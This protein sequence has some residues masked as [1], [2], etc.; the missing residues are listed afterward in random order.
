M[1]KNIKSCVNVNNCQSDFFSSNAGVR[2]GENLSPLLFSLFIND[3]E[4]HMTDMGN[5]YLD[6]SDET[7]N[8]F[9]KL[10]LLLYADDTVVFSNSPTGLQKCLDDLYIYCNK[11]KLTVN[12]NKTKII[13]FCKRKTKGNLKFIFDSNELEIVND[14]Q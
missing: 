6:F 7:C 11:W 2:Q 8:Q 14:F 4:D 12:S 9:I 10:M 1:Y 13:I 3:L 5:P